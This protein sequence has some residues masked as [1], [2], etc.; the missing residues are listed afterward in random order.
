MKFIVVT[1]VRSTDPTAPPMQY[2]VVYNPTEVDRMREGPMLRDGGLGRGEST[3]EM[4][5]HID[6]AVA[7][8]Y[9]LNKDVRILILES[10]VDAWISNTADLRGEPMERVTDVDRLIAILAKQAAGKTFTVED[11]DSVD[12]TKSTR[13]INLTPRTARELYDLTA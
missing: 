5:L 11:L 4:L 2:P 10:E 6:D 8:A 9:A 12:P 3:E 13:G 1:I 7:D